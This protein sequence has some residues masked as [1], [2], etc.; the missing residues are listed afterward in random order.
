MSLADLSTAQKDY[1]CFDCKKVIKK[2]DRLIRLARGDNYVQVRGAWQQNNPYFKEKH[3]V[4]Q[5][6]YEREHPLSPENK[7]IIP[8]EEGQYYSYLYSDDKF[9]S[10]KQKEAIIVG[11]MFYVHELYAE[12][13]ST[14]KQKRIKT[15]KDYIGSKKYETFYVDVSGVGVSQNRYICF[16]VTDPKL[17]EGFLEVRAEHERYID[18]M[19]DLQDSAS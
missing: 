18:Y 17:I 13:I 4:C 11:R 8:F 5:D 9:D 15:D 2:G 14:G 10:E 6:C 7:T 12:N 16:K 1:V 19:S 3:P